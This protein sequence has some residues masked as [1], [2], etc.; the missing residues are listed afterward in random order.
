[1]ECLSEHILSLFHKKELVKRWINKEY[2][3]KPIIIYG[4]HGQLKPDYLN[5]YWSRFST[6]V[7]E[8]TKTGMILDEYLSDTIEKKSVA[9]MFKRKTQQKH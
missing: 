1:M 6:I 9:M 2:L 3:I 8:D 7:I 5:I 4:T